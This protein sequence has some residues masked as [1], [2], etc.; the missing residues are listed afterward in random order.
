MTLKEYLKNSDKKSF[1]W[2]GRAKDLKILLKLQK[3]ALK[4][5]KK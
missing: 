2:K 4:S 3:K 5:K 1:V